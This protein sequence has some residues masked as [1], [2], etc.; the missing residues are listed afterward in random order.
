MQLGKTKSNPANHTRSTKTALLKD[1]SP[2]LCRYIFM[3]V[4]P[5]PES[6]GGI[7]Q[8]L[9]CRPVCVRVSI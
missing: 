1:R 6:N 7:L 5:R 3:P 8:A 2:K 4:T 9:C